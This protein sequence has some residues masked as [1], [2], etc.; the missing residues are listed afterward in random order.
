MKSFRF[1]R[2]GGSV[3]LFGKRAIG[4]GFPA[5]AVAGAYVGMSLVFLK[6]E[7]TVHGL[8]I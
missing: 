3:F 6:V 4:W 2:I 8:F 5:E 1:R 7:S